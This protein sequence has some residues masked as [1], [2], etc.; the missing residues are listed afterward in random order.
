M[1][2]SDAPLRTT[3]GYRVA[4]STAIAL[5][6]VGTVLLVLAFVI[7]ATTV[8]GVFLE[9][10]TLRSSL[11]RLATLTGL[12]LVRA[13]AVAASDWFWRAASQHARSA[14]RTALIE[15]FAARTGSTAR[16]SDN[17]VT[18]TTEAVDHL[19]PFITQYLPA[20]VNA[21]V[22][23]AI[24]AIAIGILDPIALLIVAFAATLLV[25]LLALIGRQTTALA[26]RR[27]A[28]LGWCHAF[29]LDMVSGL[30]TLRAF[31]RADD[32]RRAI[33][34][35][36]ARHASAAM[37][38]LRTAFQTSLVMEW[39][40]TA[41]T[42]LTAVVVSM[43]LVSDRISFASALA[44]LILTPEFFLP[45]RRLATE[46]HAGKAGA[47]ALSAITERCAPAP[48]APAVPNRSATVPTGSIAFDR[49]HF[50]FPDA[51]HAVLEDCSFELVPGTTTALVGPS[52]C[53]KS[54][55]ARLLLGLESPTGGRV[56]IG[57][58]DLASLDLAAWHAQIAWVAQHPALVAGSI[59]DNISLG[60]PHC[61]RDA[62][63]AAL[64]A[65]GLADV[66][67]RLPRGI[68]TAIGEGGVSLSG[69]QRQRIAIA[70]A[71]LRDAPIVIFDECT[72][73]LDNDTEAAILAHARALLTGRTTLLITHRSAALA[74][75]DR[76]HS[77]PDLQHQ[78]V[79][80]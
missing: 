73:H 31:G 64:E 57:T 19:D 13:V 66:V 25:V 30:G 24:A 72:A 33:A 76:V 11:P 47:A 75:A 55:V 54:T 29:F 42:A 6:T 68:D 74:L 71:Y 3:P 26:E 39:A 78:V 18:I 44:V 61:G 79:L 80:A 12:L 43:Q 7:L 70:R 77:L 32:A 8:A 22:G 37:D 28:E 1:R 35:V 52:G 59:A 2:A 17:P 50:R 60:A 69:G 48:S 53:G 36:S 21:V 45:F 41:A 20:R 49:V 23:P 9:H 65:A 58:R 10:D 40:A 16:I 5:Q 15:H 51:P 46:Y 4:R 34:T 14:L 67:A 62:M 63:W 27:L 56:L 38:V